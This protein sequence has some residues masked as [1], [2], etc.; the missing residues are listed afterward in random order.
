MRV[1]LE[2]V[3][4]VSPLLGGVVAVLLED[5]SVAVEGLAVVVGAPDDNDPFN[6]VSVASVLGK[7]DVVGGTELRLAAATVIVVGRERPQGS[8]GSL[9]VGLGRAVVVQLAD[10]AVVGSVAGVLLAVDLGLAG[11]AGSGGKVPLAVLLGV[12]F[13]CAPRQRVDAHGDPEEAAPAGLFSR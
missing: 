2:G 9:P 3:L 10:V 1:L 8:V 11:Q 4:D 6:V 13:R 7:V 5:H 12:S